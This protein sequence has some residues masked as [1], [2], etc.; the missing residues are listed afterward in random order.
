MLRKATA[1]V[2]LFTCTVF[3][4]AC[5]YY[6]SV[7]N[8]DTI[9][10]DQKIM[11]KL[12]SGIEE[13]LIYNGYL[14]SKQ[15]CYL[16]YYDG[17][18]SFCPMENIKEIRIT[19]PV[20]IDKEKLKSKIQIDEILLNNNLGLRADSGYT[21]LENYNYI[22][23]FDSRCVNLENI[24]EVRQ[25]V[26]AKYIFN[27]LE[28]DIEKKAFEVVSSKSVITKIKSFKIAEIPLVLCAKD[29][30]A[31]NVYIPIEN[32]SQISTWR[33]SPAGILICLGAIA[34]VIYYSLKS[35]SLGRT[36]SY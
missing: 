6:R 10:K 19:P 14:G 1:Y 2:L 36:Y 31:E 18:I 8:N 21:Y 20:I 24:K 4:N 35:I 30:N 22:K 16:N 9:E 5:Y 33:I 32:I 3:L 28:A 25:S 12:R 17:S 15:F 34:A 7:G 29:K 27:P 26:G 11:V 13:E 23:L